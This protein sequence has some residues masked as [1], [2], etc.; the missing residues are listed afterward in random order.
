MR[1]RRK[2]FLWVACGLA[3]LGTG[4]AL[5]RDSHAARRPDVG[6]E[7]PGGKGSL[8]YYKDGD[9]IVVRHCEG[10]YPDVKKR[11]D[12]VG[13]ENRVPIEAFK[14]AL[15]SQITIEKA[16]YL[17][18]LTK[19]EIQ[20]SKEGKPDIERL[21][22]RE[23]E[24]TALLTRVETRIKNGDC[25]GDAQC[26][27][28][29]ATATEDLKKAREELAEGSGKDA[30]IKK[31]NGLIDKLV[32]KEISATTLTPY[33]YG[34]AK[35]ELAYT[36]LKN[37]DPNTKFP[38]GGLNP[39]CAECKAKQISEGKVACGETKTTANGSVW[40]LV[41]RTESG[42]EVWKDRQSGLTFSDT[43][44]KKYSLNDAQKACVSSVSRDARGK[45]LNL[46]WS[47]PTKEDYEA[48]EAHGIREVLPN[49][50]D[51]WFWSLYPF[52]TGGAYIFNGYSG[53]IGYDSYLNFPYSVRCVGR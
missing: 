47:L 41:T 37:F 6:I 38:C 51:R 12:C 27:I 40:E 4:L 3:S 13:K 25:A 35:D 53:V 31:I 18:P 24:L 39:N 42:H 9:R 17:K 46:K 8:I 23:A 16:D 34:K 5:S 19:A 7:G 43:L 28:D 2:A 44:G 30:A 48:A 10:D 33:T 22:K 15:K 1:I 21:K 52:Y 36:V 45:L 49:M 14:L 26:L 29:Q 20:A 32:D 50:K 11:S